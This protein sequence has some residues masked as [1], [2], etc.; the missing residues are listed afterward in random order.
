MGLGII[1]YFSVP[2]EPSI[3]SIAVTIPAFAIW[4]WALRNDTLIV[5]FFCG[6][7]CLATIG[8]SASVVRASRLAF[9]PLSQEIPPAIIQG[10]VESR[11]LLSGGSARIVVNI[12]SINGALTSLRAR[13]RMRSSSEIAVPGHW[14]QLRAGL[15]PPPPPVAP[16]AFDFGR[17]LWFQGVGAVGFSLGAPTLIEPM[18]PLTTIES[19]ADSI[20]WLRASMSDRIRASMSPEYGFVATAFLTGESAAI[21]DPTLQAFRDSSLAHLLSI[22]GLHMVMAGFGFFTSLR[23]IMALI[24]GAALRLPVKKIAAIGALFAS[25]FYLLI[26]GAATPSLRSFIMIAFVFLAM[27]LDRPAL[28]MRQVAMSSVV[29]LLI[30]PE[31]V[32]DVSFQMSFAAVAALVAGYEWVQSR[33]STPSANRW[34]DHVWSWF[35]GSAVTSLIAGFATMPFA[36]YHFHRVSDYGVVAN[37][38]AMPAVGLLV[39]PAGVLALIAL[40]FGLEYWPLQVMEAGLKAVIAIAFEVASWPGAAHSTASISGLSFGLMIV[41]GLW[42]CIWW[43]SWRLLGLLPLSLGIILT[44]FRDPPDILIGNGA[45]TFAIRY[46][47]NQLAI[48]TAKRGRFEAETW[49]KAEGDSR[50]LRDVRSQSGSRIQCDDQFC[51]GVLPKRGQ[52]KLVQTIAVFSED[53]IDADIL[54]DLTSR[55]KSCA[56]S[57]LVFNANS[58][59]NEGAIAI[60]NRDGKW[61]W[62]SVA[63]QRGQRPWVPKP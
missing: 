31:S 26:S 12:Q 5:A 35:A 21:D 22:S 33:P 14:V 43:R 40:P 13:I 36:A 38:L 8:Y 15:K 56:N 42:L 4:I 45:K 34:L 7:L 9:S 58:I 19:M 55:H 61:V 50:A 24:P 20:G 44:P 51:S 16:G 29:I 53:C 48:A 54:I 3:W 41:G 10:R 25:F 6:A 17:A 59:A 37:V 27:I 28:G 57:A 1:L 11:A 46:E 47:D 18:R 62:T 39:M 32:L 60:W 49:L 30:W 63:Q 23:F 52:L 2:R